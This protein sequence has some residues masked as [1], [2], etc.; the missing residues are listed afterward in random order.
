MEPL[1]VAVVWAAVNLLGYLLLR[2]AYKDT[3]DHLIEINESLAVSLSEVH[4]KLLDQV[5]RTA[6][7]A[8]ARNDAG[9]A[10]TY[11]GAVATNIMNGRPRRPTNPEPGPVVGAVTDEEA[12]DE[13]AGISAGLQKEP[14]SLVGDDE[15]VR[16]LMTHN[17]IR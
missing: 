15:V 17:L 7:I 9:R 4:D 16:E 2:S 14:D 5:E 13:V 6:C 11:V 10:D 12:T 1:I 8:L 3:I